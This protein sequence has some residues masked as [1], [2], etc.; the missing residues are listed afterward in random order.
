M[1]RIKTIHRKSEQTD[2]S[3][4][5]SNNFTWIVFDCKLI[6]VTIHL[7]QTYERNPTFVHAHCLLFY[8]WPYSPR[9]MGGSRFLWP[10][11]WPQVLRMTDN[12]ACAVL[13][14][15]VCDRC[16]SNR[17]LITIGESVTI[18]RLMPEKPSICISYFATVK[19]D[20]IAPI[21]DSIRMKH[22]PP[23]P[24]DYHNY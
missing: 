4:S 5:C 21:Y 24:R 16:S 18:F 17:Q 11:P 15:R 1:Q 6:G 14:I 3:S 12:N 10:T 19:T 7:L 8:E 22:G 23:P 2:I 13:R 20:V 9:V